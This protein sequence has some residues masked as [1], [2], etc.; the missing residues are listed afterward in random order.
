M[1]EFISLDFYPADFY[2]DVADLTFE[3]QGVYLALLSI[4]WQRSDN[5]IPNDMALIKKALSKKG[6]WRGKN[7]I[8]KSIVPDLLNRFFR[9][10]DDGCWH[11]FRLD[12]EREK[13]RK[14]S[15]NARKSAI[16]RWE[17]EHSEK[18]TPN[19]SETAPKPEQNQRKTDTQT[20]AKHGDELGSGIEQEQQVSGC[21]G[22]AHARGFTVTVT[23]TDSSP[24]SPYGD[25]PPKPEPVAEHGDPPK[26]R[27]LV[28]VG[29]IDQAVA[30][31]NS[32][33]SRAGLPTCQKLTNARRTKLAARIRDAGGLGGWCSA[34]EKLEGIPGLLGDND[35]GWR[36]GI[37]FLLQEGSF[38]KLMEG[39]YDNWKSISRLNRRPSKTDEVQELLKIWKR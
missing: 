33:A 11:Q 10:L 21:D 5:A 13:A 31:W 28:T 32:M 39:G 8:F 15:E 34:I 1:A 9:R 14:R 27:S 2:G 38:T 25:I 3:Q 29:V 26:A 22:I 36:A 7:S 18:P 6:E 20:D 24:L 12:K 30:A 4:A 16:T 35:R 17:K 23:D 37:D 19:Q